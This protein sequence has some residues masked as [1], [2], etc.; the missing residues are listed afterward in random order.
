VPAK[1]KVRANRRGVFALD[2]TA[3]GA[4]ARDAEFARV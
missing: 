3:G 4:D 1:A 2:M